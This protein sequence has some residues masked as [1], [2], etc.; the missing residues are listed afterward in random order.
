M[1]KVLECPE[2]TVLVFLEETSMLRNHQNHLG[3]ET[4]ETIKVA[5]PS[6]PSLNLGFG[7]WGKTGGRGLGEPGG[8]VAAA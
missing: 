7:G 5:K 6:K 3:C 1:I 4:V 2:E 8:A